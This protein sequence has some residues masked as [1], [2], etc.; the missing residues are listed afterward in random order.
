MELFEQIRREYRFG[1]GTIRGVADKLRVHRRMVRQALMS[2]VPPERKAPTRAKPKL[3][4]VQSSSGRNLCT[5]ASASRPS[6]AVPTTS[7]SGSSPSK[8]HIA[9]TAISESSTTIVRI[10]RRSLFT[11]APAID[12]HLRVAETIRYFPSF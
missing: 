5:A 12:S 4:A 10:G 11:F 1:A 2:A 8:E 3:E 7:I 6:W 9:W